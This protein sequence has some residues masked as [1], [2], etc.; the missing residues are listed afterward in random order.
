MNPLVID[1]IVTAALLGIRCQHEPNS[2]STINRHAI[3]RRAGLAPGQN[4]L[5]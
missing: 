1:N 2:P 4:L 5:E 3:H